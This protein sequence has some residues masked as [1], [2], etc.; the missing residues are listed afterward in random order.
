MIEI[1]DE[2]I[3]RHLVPAENYIYGYS[4][5]TG[6]LDK[7]FNGFNYGIS[8]GIRLESGIVDKVI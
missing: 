3:Q 1:I 4:D 5:L 6:L 7:K 8:I 2:I